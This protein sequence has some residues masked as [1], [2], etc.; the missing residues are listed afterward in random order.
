M[1]ICGG[2]TQ[3]WRDATDDEKVLANKHKADIEEK[4]GQKCDTF[5][6]F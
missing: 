5:E 1:D 6:P 2:Y 4:L 3:N